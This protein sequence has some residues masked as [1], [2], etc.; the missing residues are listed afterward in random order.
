MKD[1][2]KADHFG[3]DRDFAKTGAGEA[4]G[5]ISPMT[6]TLPARAWIV[7]PETAKVFAALEAEGG[8]DVARF[9]G[10]CVRHEGKLRPAA[11]DA[12]MNQAFGG[13]LPN[14]LAI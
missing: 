7:A 1:G 6:A 3:S 11:F 13:E 12:L 14:A 5:V 10:G 8:P 9:V 4:P 2:F